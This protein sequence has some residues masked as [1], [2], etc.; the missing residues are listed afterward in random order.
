MNEY[1][2]VN[3]SNNK[4]YIGDEKFTIEDLMVKPAE[5]SVCPPILED[6]QKITVDN[7]NDILLFFNSDLRVIDDHTYYR[8]ENLVRKD[9]IPLG[10]FHVMDCFDMTTMCEYLNKFWCI[11]ITYNFME[12]PKTFVDLV[13]WIEVYGGHNRLHVTEIDGQYDILQ[14]N[15]EG[16]SYPGSYPLTAKTI[17]GVCEEIARKYPYMV[18]CWCGEPLPQAPLEDYLRFLRKKTSGGLK[19]LAAYDIEPKV[20][21]VIDIN[22]KDAII[23]ADDGLKVEYYRSELKERLTWDQFLCLN[24]KMNKRNALIRQS[25]DFKEFIHENDLTDNQKDFMIFLG[26][27]YMENQSFSVRTEMYRLLDKPKYRDYKKEILSILEDSENITIQK[28]NGMDK[29]LKYKL[30]NFLET[31]P[32]IGVMEV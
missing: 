22:K 24:Y 17:E 14:F 2:E 23:T 19:L 4:V 29:I 32:Y 15:Q 11:P 8:L 6:P 26:I 20:R 30:L 18:R 31:V 7:I 1:F 25:M 28:I 3:Q 5:G 21:R 13:D 16:D 12:C 9:R 10:W 27:V